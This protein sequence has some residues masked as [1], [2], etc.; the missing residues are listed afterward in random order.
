MEEG[1]FTKGLFIL[2]N[3]NDK[4]IQAGTMGIIVA[5]DV[6][7]I[8]TVEHITEEGLWWVDGESITGEFSSETKL[9][10]I[11]VLAGAERY[12]LRFGHWKKVL[13]YNLLEDNGLHSVQIVPLKF[14]KGKAPRECTECHKHYKAARSQNICLDC[15]HEYAYALLKDTVDTIKKQ[16][17]VYSLND[18]K[19]IAVQSYELGTLK[20][21]MTKYESWLN[22]IV[23][24]YGS[25][26]SKNKN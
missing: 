21:P 19:S 11:V 10:R 26:R 2:E 14:R 12:P 9:N 8:V 22:K 6:L 23:D 7:D 1:Y 20:Y 17:K 5:D 16:K 13:K 15:C 3:I 25:N 24:N 18:V 4:E